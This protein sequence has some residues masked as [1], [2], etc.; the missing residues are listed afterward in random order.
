MKKKKFNFWIIAF[1]VVVV[2]LLI[3]IGLKIR[4]FSYN[5]GVS[6]TFKQIA[7]MQ[8]QNKA[9]LLPTSESTSVFVPVKQI[10]ESK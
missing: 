6:D 9:I 5:R 7:E 1:I 8:Y 4:E 3:V 2:I 10:C